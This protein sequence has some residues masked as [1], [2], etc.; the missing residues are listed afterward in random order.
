MSATTHTHQPQTHGSQVADRQSPPRDCGLAPLRRA[1]Q[2]APGL[3]AQQALLRPDALSTAAAGVSG[4]GSRLPNHAQIQAS[5]G[6]HDIS[7]VQAHTGSAAQQAS[8]RLGANAYAMGNSI[9]L[10]AKGDLHTQAHEAAHC[11]QQRHGVSLSG[12]MGRP[13]DAY[14]QHADAV[15]DLV[16]QGKSAEGLLDR[17]AGGGDAGAAVQCDYRDEGKATVS[18]EKTNDAPWKD[19]PT[20]P[21]KVHG[22][23]DEAKVAST[24]DLTPDRLKAIEAS[25]NAWL[26]QHVAERIGAI[27]GV[28][29]EAKVTLTLSAGVETG[30]S[31]KRDER[32]AGIP[33]P[34]DS[35]TDSAGAKA[36][37]KAAC[38]VGYRAGL[39]DLGEALGHGPLEAR[40]PGLQMGDESLD[41]VAGM[42]ATAQIG[43]EGDVTLE[44]ATGSQIKGALLEGLAAATALAR[45]K[46]S[47]AVG[48]QG[49]AL[50]SAP[51]TPMPK[52]M[53]TAATKPLAADSTQPFASIGSVTASG[54]LSAGVKGAVTVAGKAI[55]NKK[56]GDAYGDRVRTVLQR[57]ASDKRSSALQKLV[58]I[59]GDGYTQELVGF[60]FGRAAGPTN[61]LTATAGASGDAGAALKGK[62]Q[63]SIGDSGVKWAV[64]G[65]AAFGLGGGVKTS[66]LV[67]PIELA[68]FATIVG[69]QCGSSLHELGIRHLPH[70]VGDAVNGVTQDGSF[71]KWIDSDETVREMIS[72]NTDVLV[73]ADAAK[74]AAM[75]NTLLDGVCGADDERFIHIILR[76]TINAGLL[77]Q[78]MNRIDLARLVSR[79]DDNKQ[80]V[81]FVRDVAMPH[82]RG[83]GYRFMIG[84]RTVPAPPDLGLTQ[85]DGTS[86]F[87]RY[88]DRAAADASK[89][90]GAFAP[91][92]IDVKEPSFWLVRLVEEAGTPEQLQLR[93]P[94]VAAFYGTYQAAAGVGGRIGGTAEVVQV[95]KP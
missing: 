36:T 5:F 66:G 27:T 25:V 40:Y 54:G 23:T 41:V 83:A 93:G 18:K 44:A 67:D 47:E 55:W 69:T 8:G 33:D 84:L 24:T 88:S 61:L 16:V 1:V 71:W 22:R 12:G 19:T 42:D 46:G 26:N 45:G 72:K 38:F 13:G 64:E 73:L 39:N 49:R 10:G 30:R 51:A 60:I 85:L 78:V 52:V 35:A 87:G 6:R 86:V 15:A 32:P 74:R 94:T 20:P 81:A 91:Q 90:D 89:D 11:V 77:S 21:E 58:D 37:V 50:G 56:Q 7:N 53:T 95:V 29:P 65:T 31:I 17:H 79:V 34:K 28:D 70:L 14:E 3:Q 43:V 92:L 4:G 82:L 75:I 80:A 76:D 57:T 68:R 48:E 2:L 59:L 63:L 62:L 9:A